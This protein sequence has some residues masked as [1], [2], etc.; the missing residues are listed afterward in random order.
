MKHDERNSLAPSLGRPLSGQPHRG[1]TAQGDQ[2]HEPPARTGTTAE[3]QGKLRHVRGEQVERVPAAG[4]TE[5]DRPELTVT[6]CVAQC[7]GRSCRLERAVGS[8]TD[9]AGAVARPEPQHR[10]NKGEH[11]RP[12]S[13]ERGPPAEHGDKYSGQWEK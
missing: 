2:C 1:R 9:V 7:G 13:K 6:Q 10:H 4:E 11:D 3:L 8:D 5:A 12:K